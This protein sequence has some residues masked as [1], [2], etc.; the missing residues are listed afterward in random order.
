MTISQPSREI[1]VVDVPEV[2]D[3]QATYRYNFFVPD[4]STNESGGVPANVLSR[5]TDERD[6]AFIQ[7][8]TTRVP[9]LVQFSFTAPRLADVGNLL[10]ERAQRDHAFRTTGEQNG[11]LILDNIDKVVNEDDFAS[12]SYVSIHFHDGEIDEKIH[13][14]VSGSIVQQTLEE[15]HDHD[16]SHYKAAQRFVPMLP[17][18]IKPHWIFQAM[19]LPKQAYGATFHVPAGTTAGK[20]TKSG[21]FNAS[22][23]TAVMNSYFQRLK[24]VSTN[25]QVNAK[26]LHDLVNRTIQDPTAP[27]SGDL[28]NMHAYAK[29]V[30]QAT[31]QRFSP[32][33]SEQDF[34]TFVPFIEVRKQL[35]ATHL[36]KYGAEMV[37]CIIDKF[38]V[39]PDGTT[40]AHPPI[41]IDS[42]HS[43]VCADFQVKF[44]AQYCYVA[45]AV[46][47]L[48]MPA[49][50]DDSGDVA[51]IKVLVSSKPSNKVYVSTLKL[52][53][54]P[55]PGDV[56]FVWNYESAKLTVNWAFPVTSE[57]DVKQFQV[58]RRSSV[59][60][61]FELQKAY[62]FD[63]SVVPFAA[64][65]TPDHA[66]VERL[67]SPATYWVD[68]EFDR[69]VNFSRES[70]FIYSVCAVDAHGL[71]SNYSAQFR[72]W[73]DRF[74][75]Q[76]QK[77][78][79][80]HAGAPKPYPNLYLEG[81]A[82]Q[83]TVRVG[84]PHTKRM[85][86]Y[87]NPEYYYLYDDENRYVRVLSTKQT[88]GS[89]RLQFI[90]LD[91]LKSHDLNIDIDD[92]ILVTQRK[93]AYPTV[94]FGPK[95]R[96]QRHKA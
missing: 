36:Q 10:S 81:H 82:F 8:S 61:S 4:E 83:N 48:T 32:A 23:G 1:Y 70:G 74:K 68:D 93:M 94:R 33:V 44:N 16:T 95:R 24:Q 64:A 58:F 66:L 21:L 22:A 92:R 28:V 55:P 63:D 79:V 57:R 75:N 7:Y 30:K 45:R 65:E 11:S 39:L 15:E 5:R 91:N 69:N 62:N 51:T 17:S 2:K 3:F 78:L 42:P 77:E 71:T 50:D 20:A 52:D 84:G 38:E 53:N 87:F 34:K 25:V 13:Q 14:L 43:N 88:G 73:F 76:L 37:G 9:R 56:S 89:Y 29:Q 26:F 18:I 46:A 49:I 31:N 96:A 19:T 12:N 80:S 6:A 35:T 59:D 47:L 40:K 27:G 72:V 41:V 54:P 67:T 86:L 60:N 90:N 85:K